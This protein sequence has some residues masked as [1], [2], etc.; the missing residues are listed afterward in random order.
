MIG[1]FLV[2]LLLVLTVVGSGHY[3]LWRRLVRDT[4]TSKRARRI[5]LWAF[6]GLLVLTFATFIGEDVLP[7]DIATPLAWVGYMWLALMFY[8]IVVLAVLE[9]PALVAKLMLRH[10]AR[11]AEKTMARVGAKPDVTLVELRTP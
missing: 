3:Y 9:L 5:G 6:V 4:T 8:L 1:F 10:S 7:H 11:A 2:F